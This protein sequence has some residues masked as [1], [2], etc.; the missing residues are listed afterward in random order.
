MLNLRFYFNNPTPSFFLPVLGLIVHAVG[1]GLG[2]IGHAA[3]Q[4]VGVAAQLL[5]DQPKEDGS[6]LC[7]I[8]IMITDSI[9]AG[10]FN[11]V[12]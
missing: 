4:R 3:A 8:L 5:G 2:V 9:S 6:L 1:G 11:T 10:F 7:S 12:L